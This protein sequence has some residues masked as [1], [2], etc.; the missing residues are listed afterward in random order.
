M[1][2]QRTHN[3]KQSS[4]P[5]APMLHF[6]ACAI[7]AV[8]HDA[9]FAANATRLKHMAAAGAFH[10]N[11]CRRFRRPV[12]ETADPR[13]GDVCVSQPIIGVGQNDTTRM[14]RSLLV[15]WMARQNRVVV[16]M[17]VEL[18]GFP[19]AFFLRQSL[20][21]PLPSNEPCKSQLSMYRP[22]RKSNFQLLSLCQIWPRKS[23]RVMVRPSLPTF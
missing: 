22:S 9:G 6:C 23:E 8:W 16:H 2:S 4:D 19:A 20:F 17:A 12:L 14:R 7:V 10:Q 5:I 13:S 21:P 3:P 1:S 15:P 11:H 18:C